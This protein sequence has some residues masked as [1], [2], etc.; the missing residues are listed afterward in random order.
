VPISKARG[1]KKKCDDLF[2]KIVRARG[3]CEAC[4]STSFLQTSH[5]QGRAFSALRCDFRNAHCLCAKCHWR[6]HDQAAWAAWFLSTT[7]TPEQVQDLIDRRQETTKV[8][9]KDTYEMLQSV[10]AARGIK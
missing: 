1:Y 10:A 6:W 8:D 5:I 3:A 9:W 4:G 7:H 2:S